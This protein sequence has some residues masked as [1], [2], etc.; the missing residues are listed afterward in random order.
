MGDSPGSIPQYWSRSSKP[1]PYKW[2]AVESLVANVYSQRSDVWSFGITV[3]EMFTLGGEP[4]G[5]IGPHDLT[6]ALKRGSRL[7][8]CS[9][10]P[11]RI[12]TLLGQCWQSD[13]HRRP[14]FDEVVL[15]LSQY[16]SPRDK[17]SYN[18]RTR[19]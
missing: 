6:S 18:A 11:R 1:Q 5:Q 16:M 14:S 9:L 7:E 12:N 19:L 4:Y 10:A 15:A 8:E 2:M 3:W 13:P 17:N